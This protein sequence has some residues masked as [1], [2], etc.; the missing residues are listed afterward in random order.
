MVYLKYIY[1]VYPDRCSRYQNDKEDTYVWTVYARI[2]SELGITLN[3][4]SPDDI[5]FDDFGN[6][7]ISGCKIDPKN[8][9]FVTS[10]WTLPYQQTDVT[11]MVFV[12]RCLEYCGF[13]L[14]ISPSLSV[15]T[16]D[17]YATLRYFG[18][19][20][21]PVLRSARI[22]ASRNYTRRLYEKVI[23]DI[24]FPWIVKPAY[25]G[26]GMGVSLVNNLDE[27]RGLVG[28][29]SA[30][31][32]SLIVQ[33][34]GGKDCDD[35]RVYI[36]DG[37]VKAVLRRIPKN[38]SITANLSTGGDME[39]VQ[40]PPELE[41]LVSSIVRHIDAPYFGVDFLST[42]RGFVLSEIEP[43]AAIGFPNSDEAG[44]IQRELIIQRFESYQRHHSEWVEDGQ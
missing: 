22:G 21:V 11:N 17:K 43:D 4:V 24:Q 8:A 39:F 3:L 36:I 9:I 27:M 29:A 6:A 28:L 13:Y 37:Q 41:L 33:E 30:S 42:E 2:A 35:Y 44:I 31:G 20:G 7:W 18:K 10:I 38:G 25:W 5:D 23:L 19:I 14:P 16:T 34:Y 12:Y 26:M 40:L 32:T 15:M 1:W